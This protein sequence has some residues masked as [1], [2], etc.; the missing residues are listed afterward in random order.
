MRY[1]HKNAVEYSVSLI[2]AHED[3]NACVMSYQ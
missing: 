2:G 1:Y 3:D